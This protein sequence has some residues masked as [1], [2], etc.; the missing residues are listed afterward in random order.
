[1]LPLNR[2]VVGL[3][4]EDL[5]RVP[6]VVAGVAGPPDKSAAVLAALRGRLVHVLIT[7]VETARRVLA[8]NEAEPARRRTAHRGTP[9]RR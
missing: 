8:R 1:M 3:R 9:R 6:V 2:R 4:L 7:D 5:A